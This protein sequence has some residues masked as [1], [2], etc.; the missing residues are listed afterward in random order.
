MQQEVGE[1]LGCFDLEALCQPRETEGGGE[2][3]PINTKLSMQMTT[4][5]SGGK[6]GK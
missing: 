1:N 4:N 2:S 6:T 3:D 5:E